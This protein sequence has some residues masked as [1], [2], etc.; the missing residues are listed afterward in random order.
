M[1]RCCL[2]LPL[3]FWLLAPPG[4]CTCQLPQR[5]LAAFAGTAPP[6]PDNDPED[7]PHPP[8]CTA[9]KIPLVEDRAD[10]L[11]ARPDLLP[12]ETLSPELLVSLAGRPPVILP[13]R[14]GGADLPVYLSTCAL[15]L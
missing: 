6:A 12:G 1:L 5:L 3:L 7:A 14:A 10:D 8:G 15:R 11:S 2:Y 9:R 13:V 4:I